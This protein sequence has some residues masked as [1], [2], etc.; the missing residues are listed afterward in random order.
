M[1]CRWWA[2]G[3]P[4]LHAFWM[5]RF[6][7]LIFLQETI[8]VDIHPRYQILDFKPLVKKASGYFLTS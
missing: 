7:V 5:Y 2:N 8:I 3:G 6:L 4:L 1:A